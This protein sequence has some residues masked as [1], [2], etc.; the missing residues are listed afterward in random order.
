[1][2]ASST[3]FKEAVCGKKYAKA[4]W[5]CFILN[6]FNQLTGINAVNVYANR[7]LTSMEESGGDFPLTTL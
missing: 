5:I 7:L 4:S 1:M 3:T 6:T 2:D